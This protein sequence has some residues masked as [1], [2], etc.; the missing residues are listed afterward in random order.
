MSCGINTEVD[1]LIQQLAGSFDSTLPP[2]N[3]NDNSWKLPGGQNSDIYKPTDPVTNEALTEKKVDGN[4]TFDIVASSIAAHLEGEFNSN[5]ISGGEYTKAYIALMEAA[6]GNSVQ[7]LL[8]RDQ[9]KWQALN[10]QIAAITAH[11][12]MEEMKNRVMLSRIQVQNASVEHA[13]LKIRLA[14]EG[15]NYCIGKFN[16]EQML[17]QQLTLTKEQTEAARAQTMNTRTD[18]STVAG[19]VGKQ[20]ALYDQQITSYKRNDEYRFAN[21]LTN[22]WVAQKTIDEGLLAPTNM[23]NAAIDTVLAKTKANLGI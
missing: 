15:N 10:A 13:L 1:Q 5:R 4:G 17:P 2:F 23:Q 14:T 22:T 7:F 19:S 20:N 3:P 21:M 9:A 12:Q 18:G 8:Q 6:L 11:L 16:L